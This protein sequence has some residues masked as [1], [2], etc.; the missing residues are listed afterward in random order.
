MKK[1]KKRNKKMRIGR[2]P[3]TIHA[4]PLQESTSYPTHTHGLYKIV[5][6]E[7][8][9]DPLAFGGEGNAQR[10]NS[11]YRFFKKQKNAAKLKAILNGK[12]IELTG[13][14]LDPKYMKNDPYVYC[15]REVTVKFEAVKLAYGSGVTQAIPGIRFI[16]IW[17]D[18][19]HF[20]LQDW[21]YIGGVKP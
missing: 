18:G 4:D 20:A 8:L 19:D 7:F 12:T 9:M 21:Y 5:M 17:V 15:F 3:F 13:P 11:A 14:Q 10:I 1:R 6:P 16:Q 2:Y